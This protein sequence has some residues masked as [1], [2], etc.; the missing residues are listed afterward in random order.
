MVSEDQINRVLV[1]TAHPDDVDF[2]AAGAIA[3]FTDRGVEVTYCVITDGDA[4]G[5]DREL[6]NGGMAELRRAEQSNAAKVVGVTDLRFLGY[7]DG[8]VVQSLDLR[9]DIT[10]VIR[11][12]RPDLVI[13]HSPERNHRFIAPSHP[14][15]R[16][17]GG[18]ALDAVYP[19]ARNPYAFPELLRDEGL[20]AWTVREVWLNGSPAPDHHVDV[21]DTFDRK[22]AAL[23]S[24]VSQVGHQDD[25]EESLRGHFSRIAVEAGF[26]EGRYIESFQRVVTL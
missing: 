4:G 20:E 6:D 18:C 1:V 3:R 10:R 21:T 14:D 13:T 7:R 12:V 26:G 9:R 22:L 16:A 25:F 11:Q 8:T 23:R 19:D 17:V 24:H 2:A 15:H 5:F